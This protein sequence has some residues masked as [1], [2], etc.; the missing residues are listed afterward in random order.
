MGRFDA[1]SARLPNSLKQFFQ[2]L[3]T[4]MGNWQE[5]IFAYFDHRYTNATTEAL[6]GVI[7]TVNRT[8]RGYSFR[9]LRAKMLLSNGVQKTRQV[10]VPNYG[11]GRDL[12]G[13]MLVRTEELGADISTISRLF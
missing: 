2:P 10:L 4:A 12:M 3:L 6:N 7:K 13:V 11:W 1:W 5:E 8:G 9:T